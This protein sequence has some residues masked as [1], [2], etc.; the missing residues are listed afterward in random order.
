LVQYQPGDKIKLGDLILN[1]ENTAVKTPKEETPT[2]A[3]SAPISTPTPKTTT[4]L[5]SAPQTLDPS[6][7]TTPRGTS[8]ASPSIRK[9][10]RELGVDLSNVTG[11]GQKGRVL[12]TDRAN[13]RIEG[14]A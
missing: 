9:L 12:D 1:I 3:V 10:A 8:H 2:T 7:S 11:T 5:T 4:T 6:I 14:E 13:L